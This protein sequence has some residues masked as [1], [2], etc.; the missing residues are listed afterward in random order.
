MTLFAAF[1]VL[2]RR[3]TGE[4]HS[5]LVGTP[6]A[7][8]N[9]TS[10]EPL[11]GFFVNTLALRADLSG[12]PTFSKSFCTACVR[13]LSTPMPVPTSLSSFLS[14]AFSPCATCAAIRFYK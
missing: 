2:I 8:R 7:N 12:D 14:S 5:F 10:V 3:Y 6:I 1:C 9:A 13:P 4:V 11:I